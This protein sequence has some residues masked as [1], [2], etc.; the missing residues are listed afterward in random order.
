MSYFTDTQIH[1]YTDKDI[2][3]DASNLHEDLRNYG[4]LQDQQ[5]PLVVSGI[6]LALEKSKCGTGGQ[7]R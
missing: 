7:E 2:L 6:L 5:K 4:N 1:I 3:K